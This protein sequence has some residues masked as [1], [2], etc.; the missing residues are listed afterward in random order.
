MNEAGF[1]FKIAMIMKIIHDSGYIYTLSDIY[2]IDRSRKSKIN[3][4]NRQELKNNKL[5]LYAI[6]TKIH[7]KF[8]VCLQNIHILVVI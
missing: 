4:Y 2:T 7:K 3:C 8:I 6:S 1:L 5:N